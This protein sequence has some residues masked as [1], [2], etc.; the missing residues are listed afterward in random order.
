MKVDYVRHVW[1]R[2]IMWDMCEGWL[3]ETYDEDW[4]FETCVMIVD[5]VRHVWWRLIM[6][7]MSGNHFV[8]GTKE[9]IMSTLST[10]FEDMNCDLQTALRCEWW[11][12]SAVC[13]W[14][15]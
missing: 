2:L 8:L 14:E 5:Y 6:W 4:L 7:D 10:Q 13:F 1:W 3:C 11:G 12:M 9:A 15:R